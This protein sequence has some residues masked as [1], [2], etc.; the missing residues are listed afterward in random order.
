MPDYKVIRQDNI[1][2]FRDMVN[3]RIAEGYRPVGGVAVVV[4]RFNDDYEVVNI[5]NTGKR[6]MYYQALFRE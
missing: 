6:V 1:L 2:T 5:A 4:D 3:A